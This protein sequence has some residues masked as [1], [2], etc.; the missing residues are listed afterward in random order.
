MVGRLQQ[1]VERLMR[2]RAEIF[3][4]VSKKRPMIDPA[5]AAAGAPKR[6]RTDPAVVP[7]LEVKPLTPGSHSL[8]DIFTIAR[9]TGLHS[10]DATL[11]PPHLASRVIVSTL[12]NLHPDL[13]N[14]AITVSTIPSFSLHS[15]T[16]SKTEKALLTLGRAFVTVSPHCPP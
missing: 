13:L 4:E 11:I 6:Q 7:R 1:H 8:A 16:C 12:A 5:A 10:F 14:Q 9:N 2:S 3:D 15:L